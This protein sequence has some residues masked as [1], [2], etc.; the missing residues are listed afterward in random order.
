[1]S[2]GDG[3]KKDWS[4]LRTAAGLATIGLT[5]ALS[6]GIG[7]GFGLLLDNWLKTNGLLVIAGSIL[8]IVAGFKQLIQAVMRAGREQDRADAEERSQRRAETERKRPFSNEVE[9]A[10]GAL[11]D[12][13]DL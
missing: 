5:L 11:G 7:I 12:Q 2:G 1:M 9:G 13:E 3:P 4:G 8:G 6:V 10:K